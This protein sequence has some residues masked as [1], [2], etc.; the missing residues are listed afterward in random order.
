[1]RELEQLKKQWNDIAR[2]RGIQASLCL[3]GDGLM[4]GGTV[5]AKRNHDASLALEGDEA[6]ILTLLSVAYEKALDLSTLKTIRRASAIARDGDECK[7]AMHIALAKLPKISDPEDAARRL[8]IADGL[9]AAG[10]VPRDIWTALEFDPETLDSLAKYDQDEPRVAAGSGKPSGEWTSGGAAPA[11]AELSSLAAAATA[12]PTALTEAR[13]AIEAT[14][15]RI[16]KIAQRLPRVATRLATLAA[17]L[18]LWLDVAEEVLQPSDTGGKI[19]SGKVSGMPNVYYERHQDELALH[20]IDKSTGHTIATVYPTGVRGQYADQTGVLAQMEGDELVIRS[21][22][23]MMSQAQTQGK[24]PQLC[25]DPPVPD[26]KGMI[27]SRGD[28]SKAYELFMKEKTNPEEITPPGMA[29]GLVNSETGKLVKFDDCQHATGDMMEYKGLGI[30][31]Q[32]R[33]EPNRTNIANRF[34]REATS[35]VLASDG[36][37]VVWNFAELPALEFARTLF[38]GNPLLAGIELRYEPWAEGERWRWS[39][40][41]RAWLRALVL[42]RLRKRL[43]ELRNSLRCDA[44]VH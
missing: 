34:I 3:D 14:A 20:I 27:G 9:I 37:H 19:I 41:K 26:H 24:K 25:P 2:F 4:L 12:T 42:L 5:V 13:A 36:R 31:K 28:R 6:R 30:A 10:V 11:S 21:A 38:Q 18:N 35:Q 44:N 40:S 8:F 32:L 15:A 1:M 16:P 7:A 39:R 29:F 17:H 33:Y 43:L 22:I 23:G